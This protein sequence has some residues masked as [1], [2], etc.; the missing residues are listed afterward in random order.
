MIHPRYPSTLAALVSGGELNGKADALPEPFGAMAAHLAAVP[1]DNALTGPARQEA[2]ALARWPLWQAMLAARPDRDE[3]VKAMGS[4]DASELPPEPE[5]PPERC[6]TLA[7]VR[8]L[9]A[10]QQWIWPG[11]LA[12]GVLNGLAAD[13]GTGKTIM[14]AD[15]ARR[16]YLGL[17]LPDGQ[18]NPLPPGTRT[19]WVPGDRHYTQLI[20]LADGFGVPDDALIL[21]APASNPTGGLDMDDHAELAALSERIGAERPGVVVIDTVGMTTARNLCRPEDARDY[22]GPLMDMAHKAAIPFLLLTHLS[23]DGQ[24]LGRRI[25]GACRLVW[26]ITAPD[27]DGQ[28][29][30]RRVWVDKSYVEKPPPL[31]MTIAAPGCEFDFNPPSEPLADKGG[32]PPEKLGKAVAFLTEKLTERDRKYVELIKEWE[33]SGEAKGTIFNACR[34]MEDDG[35][36]VIDTTSKPKICHLVKNP[37]NRQEPGS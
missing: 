26:K 18:A 7:D 2:L 4:A 36:L 20:G 11:W 17:N 12:V 19:L 28:P 23:K 33:A 5:P 29:N 8:R 21:N 25:N 24:A 6:A 16:L 22:F 30:R 14:A 3:L 27:L 37:E 34:A 35:R 31:G 10:E 1:V 32:R 15:L 9:V 13:P